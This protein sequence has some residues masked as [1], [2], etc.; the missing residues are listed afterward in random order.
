MPLFA[1]I[2]TRGPN[3]GHGTPMEKQDAWRQHADLMNTMVADG[4]IRLGGPLEEPDVL[5]ICEAPS[6]DDIRARLAAD[7]WHRMGLL[8]IKAISAWT[9]RLGRLP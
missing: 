7:P 6:A 9:L 1:V 5:L 3:Y 8:V 4:F 2:L